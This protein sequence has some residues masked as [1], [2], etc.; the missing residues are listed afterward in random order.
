MKT[1]YKILIIALM[2]IPTFAIISL[3]AQSLQYKM[4]IE[5]FERNCDIM[6]ERDNRPNADCM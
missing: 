4:T 5:Q 3:V 2:L 6:R 1:R